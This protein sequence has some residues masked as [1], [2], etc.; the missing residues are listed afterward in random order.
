MSRK[1]ACWGCPRDASTYQKRGKR[2]VHQDVGA[3]TRLGGGGVS[4]QRP[5][6]HLCDNCMAGVG[7][8]DYIEQLEA[9]NTNLRESCEILKA[10]DAQKGQI[11]TDLGGEVP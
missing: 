11:I 1:P 6:R 5:S 2:E 7:I 8:W 9:E 10:L 4:E 3:H